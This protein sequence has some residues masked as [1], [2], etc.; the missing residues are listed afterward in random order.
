MN[1][2]PADCAFNYR[3]SVFK[4]QFRGEVA[5]LNVT[6]RLRKQPRFNTSYGAIGEE[7]EKMGVKDLSIKAI[8]DAVIRIRSSKLPDPKVI[9]NAGSFFKNPEIT[10]LA[11]EALKSKHP[12]IV[13]HE[14]AN[15]RVKL[16]AGWLI[17]Q[18][19]FK[20]MRRGD[21][22]VHDKQ[23]LVL[24]NYGKATGEEILQLS[25][26]IVNTVN[27]KFGVTLEREVNVV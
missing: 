10:A 20:G 14:L 21:A 25:K 22:G 1:F 23:S 18:C 4:N 8:S 16:A 9:G 24:V 3:D 19:G 5:L 27:E 13:G 7:L 2:T 17:E 11:F 26:E 6:F 12:G 15:R